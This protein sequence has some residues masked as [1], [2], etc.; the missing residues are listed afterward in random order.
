MIEIFNEQASVGV[1]ITDEDQIV[2]LLAS[3]MIL[4]GCAFFKIH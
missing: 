3:N 2:Y 1:D 4:N